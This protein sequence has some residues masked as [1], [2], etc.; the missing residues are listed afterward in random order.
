[1]S[2]AVASLPAGGAATLAAPPPA[3][4]TPL[5]AVRAGESTSGPGRPAASWSVANTQQTAQGHQDATPALPAAGA[6]PS[7]KRPPP[8]PFEDVPARPTSPGRPPLPPGAPTAPSA[9]AAAG[10]ET[11]AQHAGPVGPADD[12]DNSVAGR[13]DS[14]RR[15]PRGLVPTK[16]ALKPRQAEGDGGDQPRPVSPA[17]LAASQQYS[18]A[19]SWADTHGKVRGFTDGPARASAATQRQMRPA[20]PKKAL[21]GTQRAQIQRHF[22]AFV[23]VP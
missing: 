20:P 7:W 10:A 12:A 2:A 13:V 8:S 1:M 5:A 18:R 21:R 19:L 3:E 15:S 14:R 4:V 9:A 23:G 6:W 11:A 17:S 22:A 16:P